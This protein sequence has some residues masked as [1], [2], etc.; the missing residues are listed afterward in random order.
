MKNQKTDSSIHRRMSFG[1]GFILCLLSFSLQAQ[2]TPKWTKKARG[3]IFSIITYDKQNNIQG[4]GNG[5][6]ISETGE[7]VSDYTLFKGVERAII[8][9]AT[10]K[11]LPVKQILGADDMYDIIKFQVDTQKEK[12]TVLPIATSP[13]PAGESVWL[14]PYSTQKEMKCQSGKVEEIVQA[15]KEYS[16]Y[17]LRLPI[18]DKLVS[19]PITNQAGEVIAL[20]QA[21]T[22]G[23]EKVSYA[24]D[25]RMAAS[26]SIGALTAN[27]AALRSIGIRKALPATEKEALVFLYMKAGGEKPEIYLELLNEFISTYPTTAE[28]YRRRAEHYTQ[29]FKDSAH[30][31]L[32]EQDIKKAMSLTDRKD[33]IH[34]ALCRMILQHCTSEQHF[35]YKDWGLERSLAECRQAIAID[36]IPLYLQTEGDLL[37]ALRNYQ[38]AHRAYMAVNASNLATASTWY[39]AA[40]SLRLTGDTTQVVADSVLALINHAVDSYARPYPQEAAPYIW[41]RAKVLADMSRPREAVADYNEYYTLLNGNVNDLFYYQREQAAIAGRM[42]QLAIDDIARAIELA[43]QNADYLAEQASLYVRFNQTDKA[44]E[45]CKKA[46]AIFPDYPDCHRILGICHALKGEKQQAYECL[47]KAKELGDPHAAPLI[48][49][50][51]K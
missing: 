50:Y 19:C 28:G 18:T 44:M 42:N 34:F 49:R 25:V 47:M 22:A 23:D 33:D 10:G 30:Y 31:E 41:E 24:I 40:Q 15:G 2:E 35:G 7:A 13:T 12:L 8:I 11:Q 14:L 6:F 1:W 3:A 51:C 37:F 38:E 39:A 5:F 45:S 26:L 17:T 43:P 29:A 27:S 21:S 48:E 32:A 4:T 36:S 20:A 9:T 16:Y 46:L